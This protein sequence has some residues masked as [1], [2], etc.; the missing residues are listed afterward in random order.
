MKLID[1]NIFEKYNPPDLYLIRKIRINIY[2]YIYEIQFNLLTK[3][4]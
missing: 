3:S 2:M 1:Q 4:V